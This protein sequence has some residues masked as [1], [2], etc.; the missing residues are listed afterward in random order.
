MAAS[1]SAFSRARSSSS[2]A[3]TTSATS[4]ASSAA[5]GVQ[6]GI[7]ER[8]LERLGRA[9]DPRQEVGHAAVGGRADATVGDRQEG[10]I[11][12]D[13]DVRG[14]RQRHPGS[15]CWAVDRGDDR[16]RD[17][18]DVD[19]GVVE[20]LGAAPYLRGEVHVLIGDAPLEPVDVATGAEGAAGAGHDQGPDRG[21]IG[22]P[23]G[24]GRELADQLGAHRVQGV[25]TVQGQRSHLAVDLDLERLELGR[26]CGEQ[27]NFGLC[28]FCH[29]E[30]P[31]AGVP[32]P[33][34]LDSG[35]EQQE[36]GRAAAGAPRRPRRLRLSR[37]GGRRP[38]RG[39]GELDPQTGRVALRRQGR[40]PRGREWAGRPS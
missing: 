38:L 28:G 3:G 39:Q 10:L 36:I 8:Q 11:R 35:R 13:P 26:I 33:Y 40:R 16:V 27:G 4:P 19:D 6:V 15:R 14:Q 32:G 12:G 17:A 29:L 1:F 25:G 21:A 30:P 22:Q 7:V 23:G 34:P 37:Q 18:A 9:D 20:R 31:R 24:G 2:S 5:L